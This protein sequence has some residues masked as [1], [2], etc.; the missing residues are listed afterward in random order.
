M[1]RFVK[2]RST[3]LIVGSH[4]GLEAVVLGKIAGVEGKLIVLEPLWRNY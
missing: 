3:V 1:A 2:K 4:I